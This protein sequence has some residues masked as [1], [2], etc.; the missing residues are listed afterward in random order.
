MHQIL[1]MYEIRR[2]CIL[3]LTECLDLGS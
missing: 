2:W 1:T 3:E